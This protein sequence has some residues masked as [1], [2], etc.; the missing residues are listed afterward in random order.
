M[1]APPILSPGIRDANGRL[2]TNE[3]IWRPNAVSENTDP[4]LPAGD[5][6]S[7]NPVPGAAENNV[8]TGTNM[9]AEDTGNPTVASTQKTVNVSNNIGIQQ[10]TPKPNV[11]DRFSSYTYHASV[12]LLTP[13][14]YRGLINSKKKSVNGYNL[15]FQSG[16]A[17]NNS[18]GFQGALGANNQTIAADGTAGINSTQIP[19]GT[20]VS[21]GRNPAFDLDFYIDSIEITTLTAGK[22]TQSSH[23]AATLKFSVVEP[24]GISLID[25]LYK[26]VQDHAPRGAGGSINYS[27]AAYLMVIRFYGYDENGNLVPGISGADPAVGNTDP[28]SV[29]EKFIP[30][31][32]GKINWGV[33]NKL[34][35]YD[36]ECLPYGQTI[37]LGQ[38]RGTIPY[39]VQL[40]EMT[41]GQLLGGGTEYS[42]T[43]SS[44][45]NPGGATTT[46]VDASGRQGLSDPR[47]AALQAS[48]NKAPPKANAATTAKKS[49]K[50]G[51][52][53]AINDFQKAQTV[54][55]NPVYSVADEYRIVFANGAEDIENATLVLPGKKKEDAQTPMAAPVS[56]Q[57]SNV[58]Q[59]KLAKDTTGKNFAITAGMQ[60]IQAIELAIRNS[61]YV[62]NQ[63]LT[64]I[65]AESGEEI[66]KASNGNPVNWFNISVVSEP[67]EPYDELRNDYAQRIT[68]IVSK[69]PLQNYESKYFPPAKFKG[70]HKSYPYWFTGKNTAVLEYQEQL[71]SL[72]NFTVSG[73]NPSNSLAEQTRR[74]LISAQRDQ[75]FY[76]YQSAS[77]DTRQGSDGKGNEVSASIADSLYSP[78]DL[79]NCKMKIVGDPAWIQQGSLAGGIQTNNFDYSPFNP[80]GSINFESSQVMFEVDW[81]RPFDYN[82]DLGVM[83][84]STGFGGQKASVQSRIYQCRKVINEFKQ[85]KFE[86]VLEGSLFLYLKP[87]ISNKAVTAPAPDATESNVESLRSVGTG[88]GLSFERPSVTIPSSIDSTAITQTVSRVA[89]GLG[90]TG[91]TQSLGLKANPAVF[92]AGTQFGR[93]NLPMLSTPPFNG[94]PRFDAGSPANTNELG[95]PAVLG[96]PNPPQPA[97]SGSGG[98]TEL[99][100]T[101]NVSTVNRLVNNNLTKTYSLSEINKPQLINKEY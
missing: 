10:V 41:V 70:V 20:Q 12:Y 95:T 23:S 14:Q 68:Y 85:G 69:Y 31:R 65:D 48:L 92:A 50:Q 22:S 86:Q 93:A 67:I 8:S 28:S 32:I 52:M 46:Q 100:G 51:L 24:N 19:N 84:P 17:P 75:P 2:L 25:R 80:D 77:A 76:N 40:S 97:T 6:F 42:E 64:Q 45:E 16:G 58:N 34:V 11:L 15:L 57:P 72:F 82:T 44:A 7:D 63:A 101:N 60:V 62:Y 73:S 37:A 71:N 78:G 55:T 94:N 66:A 36:F 39:D 1:A 30:F 4:G 33:T 26:A 81:K 89:G 74:K 35:T 27:A 56:Q 47:V 43:T 13:Q 5:Y 54:G 53:G 21:A 90:L 59:A 29:V 61:S 87:D 38:R 91:I 9:A 49:I 98:G 18:G 96:Y 83:D 99:V 88:T 79:A 3:E